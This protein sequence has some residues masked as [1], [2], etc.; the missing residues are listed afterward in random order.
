MGQVETRILSKR[1]DRR[2]RIHQP[3]AGHQPDDIMRFIGAQV[4]R[5]G[6]ESDALLQMLTL[7]PFAQLAHGVAAPPAR[8][9]RGLVGGDKHHF[10]HPR[11][12]HHS[13][14]PCA[15]HHR[16][17]AEKNQPNPQFS[18]RSYRSRHSRA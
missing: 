10:D 18:R 2:G 12:R 5:P 14:G 17:Q 7:N 16:Q 4:A 8:L 1:H 6:R 3:D 11:L 13:L 15:F 9:G